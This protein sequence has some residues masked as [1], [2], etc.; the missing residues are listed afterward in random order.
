MSLPN[1]ESEIRE[2]ISE[3]QLE[4]LQERGLSFADL[5]EDEDGEYILSEEENGNPGEEGYSV[6][7]KRI[8]L[9]DF[10]ELLDN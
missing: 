4:W 5:L 8:D 10:T 3:R 2:F 7:F 9:P 1:K 6:G